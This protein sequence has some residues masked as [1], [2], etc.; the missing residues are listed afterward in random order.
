MLFQLQGGIIIEFKQSST[1]EEIDFAI[2]CGEFQQMQEAHFELRKERATKHAN[3][4][5]IDV[6][7]V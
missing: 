6:V 1:Q 4:S 3:D 2:S 5:L 7:L